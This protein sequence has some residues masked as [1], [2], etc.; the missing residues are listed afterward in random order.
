MA[1][2][3]SLTEDQRL[4]LQAIYDRFRADGTW[5]TFITVDRPLRRAQGMDTGAVA[6]TIPESLL[7]RPRPGYHRPNPDDLPWRHRQV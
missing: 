2:E 7:P 5:P 1:D 6:Q 4:V 3:A